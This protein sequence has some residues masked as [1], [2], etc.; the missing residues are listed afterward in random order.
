MTHMEPETTELE[1]GQSLAD[2]LARP[3]FTLTKAPWP[4]CCSSGSG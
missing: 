2:A 1:P 4:T 3:A